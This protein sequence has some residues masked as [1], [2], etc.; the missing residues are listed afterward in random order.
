M[1]TNYAVEMM[2]I[3]KKFG[4]FKAIDDLN[5]KV[6]KGSVHALLGE[7]GA[8]KSTLMNLLFG[9]YDLD[10]GSIRID[11]QD[12]TISDPNVAH[13][14]G[15]GMVH[16]H[17][18]L[19]K[20]FTI[21]E[22][23]TLGNEHK[24]GIFVDSKKCVSSVQ[25]IIDLYNFGL[26]AN[27][28]VSDLSV[29]QQQRV[30]IL[31]MLYQQANILIFDEPTGALTPQETEEL[32]NTI[33]E[34]K[35]M[36]KTIIIITHKL[37][38]IKAVADECT[39][40][41]KGLSID[42]VNVADTS[43]D[44]LA[45]LMVGRKV[46]FSVN[47]HEKEAGRDLLEVNDISVTDKRGVQTLKPTSFTVKAGEILGIAGVDGNG[48]LEIVE[49]ITGLSKVS[50]G[51]IT[52]CDPK[53]NDLID[54]TNINARKISELHIA[55]IP[56]D[57]HKHGVVLD[58]N[59]AQNACLKDYYKPEYKSG[60]VLNEPKMN[61]LGARLMEE[62]D[63]RAPHGISSKLRDMSGGNQQ[64]LIIARE[65]EQKPTIL[66]ASQ[67]TRGVDVGAIENI[68]QKLLKV[69]DE[70]NAV[71]LYSLELDEIIDL[72]DRILVMYNGEAM[73]I[74]DPREVSKN[75]IGLLMAG[76]GLK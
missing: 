32:L 51:T 33:L 71:I 47:K 16:Q 75:E 15:I 39:I 24:S 8:G 45:E 12:V 73:G 52:Y 26:D 31:K 64:K 59:I 30:E 25:E 7:N 62:H 69:R 23:V 58:F 67:P 56:Q 11:G 36:G 49:A 70:N 22:N 48:Q 55:H 29:G 60:L 68:H 19:V 50:S 37:N 9:F 14:L 13:D 20:P 46:N 27:T 53:T 42:T 21:A 63:I 74:V 10:G 2:N 66:V 76:K 38:E 17:F 44:R 65:L 43:S 54:I 4:S 35:E 18:K 41:R 28:K 1:N 61:K 34:L 57:R 40:I 6:R 72:S 3:T 5:L